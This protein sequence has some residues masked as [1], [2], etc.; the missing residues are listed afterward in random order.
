MSTPGWLSAYVV[1]VCAFFVGMVVFRSISLVITPPAVSRP[2][3]KGVTSSKSRSCTCD[4]P[5]PVK[6]AACTAAPKATASSGLMDLQGSL[7]L[8]NSW[9]IACTLGIRVDPPTST[10]SCTFF[11]SIP[12]SRRVFSGQDCSLHGRTEGHSFVRV[13]G[14]ARLL[15]VKELLDHCLHFGDTSGST[16][17]H[18]LVHVFLVDS[19]V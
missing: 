11:L 8:Q 16:N 13:D 3:D 7:P 2:M 5:S 4:E 6:I 1:K 9:I 15:A 17:Q 18:N 19:A 14:P 12:L 10:T